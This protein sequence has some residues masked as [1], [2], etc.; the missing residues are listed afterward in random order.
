MEPLFWSTQY[1]RVNEQA[2]IESQHKFEKKYIDFKFIYDLS[3]NLIKSP[4]KSTFGGVWV[5]E[6]NL[7]V[8]FFESLFN[9]IFDQIDE[10]L[11]NL[12]IFPPAYFHPAKF[13]NQTEAVEILGFNKL[14]DDINYHINLKEWS[15]S[16]MSKG[17][18]KKVRQFFESGGQIS[19]AKKSEYITAYEVLRSNREHR[20][21]RMSMEVEK[22]VNNLILLPENYKLY[23]AKIGIKIAAV[24]YVVRIT[25]E[26]NYVLFWG[27]NIEFRSLSP[28]ASLLDFLVPLSLRE[29]CAILD[30]GISSVDGELDS[31]LA[32][33]KLN[34]GALETAKPIYWRQRLSS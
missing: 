7:K 10:N 6:N 23:V 9:S 24:A 13:V 32:R 20:G 18:R 27:D 15:P 30:L 29:N 26:I 19:I 17:N 5:S 31:G 22:F 11:D 12:I 14:H 2:R 21:A 1:C 28:V 4:G 16:L 3:G 25:K 33:F 34:L 8:R